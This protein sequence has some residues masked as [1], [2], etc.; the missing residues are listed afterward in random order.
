MFL[1]KRELAPPIR[2]PGGDR[3]A[4]ARPAPQVDNFDVGRETNCP[5]PRADRGAEVD[6]FRVHEVALVQQP[7]GLR[8]LSPD[9]QTCASHPSGSLG[10]ARGAVDERGND[11]R[12]GNLTAKHHFLSKLT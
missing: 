5:S 1:V 4:G 11:R 3:V 7:D 10:A 6:I 12:A 8:I 2:L 9:E